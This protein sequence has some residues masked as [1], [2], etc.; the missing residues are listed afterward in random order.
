[1]IEVDIYNIQIN[2]T[3]RQVDSLAY[4]ASYKPSKVVVILEITGTDHNDK[5]L[6]R[7][8]G[9]EDVFGQYEFDLTSARE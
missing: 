9:Y 5:L 6:F 7:V 1:M 3:E 8:K 2:K 4:V